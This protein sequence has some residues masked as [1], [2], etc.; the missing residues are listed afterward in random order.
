MN[1][2][3]SPSPG[4]V[5]NEMDELFAFLI[6]Q[7]LVDDQ[8]FPFLRQLHED[9]CEVSF[10]GMEWISIAMGDI[11]YEDIHRE[12]SEK[13]AYNIKFL[14]GG[15]LQMMYHFAGSRLVRHRLAYFPSPNLRSFSE[16]PEAYLKDELYLDIMSRR[17]VPFP[18]RFD[19]DE[20]AFHDIE[21]PKC[22]LTL[23]DVKY[24][25]IPVS[26][27]LTPGRF[28]GFV[29]RNFYQTNEHLFINDLPNRRIN[30]PQCITENECQIIHVVVPGGTVV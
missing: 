18:L 25:R 10:N 2:A 28:I 21:H 4:V 8:N 12:L 17:I 23:G 15:L 16:Y 14:D 11:N 7:G 22:H 3:N 20:R 26:A 9:K 19:F 30:F 29:L 13:R 24:C 1:S 27:P 5:K 6:E